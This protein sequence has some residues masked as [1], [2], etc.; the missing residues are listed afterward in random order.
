MA[1][2]PRNRIGYAILVLAASVS[3][4]PPAPPAVSSFDVVSIHLVP[5]NTPPTMRS[6]DFTPVLPGG[7]YI[8]SRA[9]LFE[10]ISFAY[11]VQNYAQLVGLPNWA[12]NQSYS[13]SAKPADGFP[14]LPPSENREQVRLMMRAMLA[15]RFHLQIHTET[16]QEPILN[17]ATGNGGMK[18]KE[19]D[20]PV[21]PDSE[22]HVNAAVGDTGGRMI[23]RKATMAGLAGVLAMFL[24]RPVVDQTGLKGYYDF[25][26]RWS[27]EAP[28]G[29]PPTPGLG[30]EGEGLLISNLQS[31]FGLR[32]TKALG[33]VEYWVV[34]QVEPPTEN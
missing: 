28:Q 12:K 14:A 24:K 4:Q 19:V 32:L 1:L 10:M 23:A 33:P 6:Q 29:Q 20:P 8:H 26:V 13:V 15:D 7:Q 3:A 25:D 18:I 2:S 17:L 16:R 9:E 22:G 27:A 5:P 31:Q 11:Q 21:P 30:T 34:D